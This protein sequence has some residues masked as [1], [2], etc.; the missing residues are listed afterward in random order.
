MP[1]LVFWFTERGT[2]VGCGEM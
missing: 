1:A 2:A